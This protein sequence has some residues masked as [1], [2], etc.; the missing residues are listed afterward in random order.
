MKEEK[1]KKIKMRKRERKEKQNT[2][3]K[4]VQRK[5]EASIY[6]KMLCI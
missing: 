2:K 4:C 3:L 1:T 6:F 5:P